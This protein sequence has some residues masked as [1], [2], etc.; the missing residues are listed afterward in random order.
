MS[1]ASS[2]RSVLA[3]FAAGTVPASR[4]AAVAVAAYYTGNPAER[5]ALRPLVEVIERTSP[6]VVELATSE[7][8]AGFAV[9]SA[10]RPFPGEA[11]AALRDAAQAA[12][13]TPWGATPEPASNGG[14]LQRLLAGVRRLFSGGS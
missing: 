1:S 3:G 14:F 5:A 12:L 9:R 6:G 13:A 10:E 2:V 11:E 8:G 7:D 4:A